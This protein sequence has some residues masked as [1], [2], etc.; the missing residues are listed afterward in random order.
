MHIYENFTN[1][2]SG[3]VSKLHHE[4]VLCFYSRKKWH[5][6]GHVECRFV[7]CSFKTDPKDMTRCPAEASLPPC[8]VTGE[9][10]QSR[11]TSILL[12]YL[13]GWMNPLCHYIVCL[14]RYKPVFTTKQKYD[15]RKHMYGGDG[16]HVKYVT[17][18]EVLRL[19]SLSFKIVELRLCAG[20]HFLPWYSS[21]VHVALCLALYWRHCTVLSASLPPPLCRAYSTT[22]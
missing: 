1:P 3:S 16:E 12:A 4:T 22:V 6:H 9:A 7:A 18:T 19:A 10:D 17:E 2:P 11:A 5:T 20:Y 13:G 14:W 21:L 8:H 15:Q